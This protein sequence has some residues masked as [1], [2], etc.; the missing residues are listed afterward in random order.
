MCYFLPP[1]SCLPKSSSEQ[2]GLKVYGRDTYHQE[3]ATDSSDRHERTDLQAYTHD[4][5]AT[6]KREV[7]GVDSYG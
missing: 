1:C 4:L 5:Q 3:Q 7:S 6:L 2:R